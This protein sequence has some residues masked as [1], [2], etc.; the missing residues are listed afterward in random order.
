MA[1][2]AR[3]VSGAFEK[4]APG[5]ELA[6]HSQLRRPLKLLR[7]KLQL[8]RQQ[9]RTSG[10]RKWRGGSKRE[11]ERHGIGAGF[12]QLKRQLQSSKK[13]R[14]DETVQRKEK[15]QQKIERQSNQRRKCAKIPFRITPY[16]SCISPPL[17][18][19]HTPGSVTA[20]L[21]RLSLD[22]L[23]ETTLENI[24]YYQYFQGHF[25]LK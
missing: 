10:T 20:S 22:S 5:P 2:R 15:R 19:L 25:L 23:T 14:V 21:K 11:M 17:P 9:L 7:R 3:K 4:R 24:F 8:S 6:D 12:P 1:L 16:Y 13:W 18:P